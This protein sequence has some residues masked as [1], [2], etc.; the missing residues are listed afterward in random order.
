MKSIL[1]YVV[2]WAGISQSACLALQA[3]ESADS[4]ITYP[5]PN[6]VC[7]DALPVSAVALRR[8]GATSAFCSGVIIENRRI[9]TAAHCLEDNDPS[10]IEVVFAP[11]VR[12][13]SA[14]RIAKGLGAFF[15]GSRDAAV[16]FI[17]AI[18]SGAKGYVAASFAAE[19]ANI[20]TG[21]ELRFLGYGATSTETV[22]ARTTSPNLLCGKRPLSKFDATYQASGKEYHH[23][24]SFGSWVDYVNGTNP[25]YQQSRTLPDGTSSNSAGVCAGDS[26]GPIF[27]NAK[28]WRLFG[29]NAAAPVACDVIHSFTGVDIRDIRS[30]LLGAEAPPMPPMPLPKSRCDTGLDFGACCAQVGGTYTGQACKCAD[31][32]FPN[33]YSQSCVAP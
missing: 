10:G 19:D 21:T 22:V 12:T 26:G 6:A 8:V 28:G 17:A 23:G 18:P 2:L 27:V 13:A 5:S 30:E 3:N 16:L 4:D 20:S 7:K 15:S 9:A 25:E 33:P 14:D 32:R 1:T 24:F 11:D 31:G 29:L